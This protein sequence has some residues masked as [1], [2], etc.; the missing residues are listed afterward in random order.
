M[1]KDLVKEKDIL[2]K[3]LKSSIKNLGFITAPGLLASIN[4]LY[5]PSSLIHW[6]QDQMLDSVDLLLSNVPGP[7]KPLYLANS[8]LE[9]MIPIASNSRAKAFIPLTS[10]NNR[11]RFIFSVDKE[12]EVDHKRIV[13]MVEEEIEAL[14]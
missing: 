2:T 14:I 4:A 8:K 12:S 6:I 7:T 11:F 9:Y 1:M 3:I 13:N 10:Y 5:A